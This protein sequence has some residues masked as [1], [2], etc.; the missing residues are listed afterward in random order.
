MPRGTTFNYR[1]GV[2]NPDLFRAERLHGHLFVG[3]ASIAPDVGAALC[4]VDER[5]PRLTQPRRPGLSLAPGE[6]Q[7]LGF[8]L[9]LPYAGIEPTKYMINVF[10][11]KERVYEPGLYLDQSHLVVEVT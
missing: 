9:P 10:L 11:F 6:S 5:F 8:S 3:P 7:R 1:L 2:F 4:S